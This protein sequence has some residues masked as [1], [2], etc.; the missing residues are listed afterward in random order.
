MSGVLSYYSNVVV[1]YVTGVFL[2]GS[3][4]VHQS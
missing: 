1:S 3:I 4:V 2:A